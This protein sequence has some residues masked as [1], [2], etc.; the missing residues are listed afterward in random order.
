HAELP[1]FSHN[2]FTANYL[3]EAQDDKTSFFSIQIC[4]LC[5]V[6]AE[7]TA[8]NLIQETLI[9]LKRY[10]AAKKDSQPQIRKKEKHVQKDTHV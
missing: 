10:T 4:E 3:Q 8:A 7:F 9:L 5:H 2:K 6:F 1:D